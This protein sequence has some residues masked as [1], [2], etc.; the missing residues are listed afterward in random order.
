MMRTETRSA[1]QPVSR[2]L[3][4]LGLASLM[5]VPLGAQGMPDTSPLHQMDWGRQTFVYAEVLDYAPGLTARPLLLD[6]AGWMGGSSHRLWLK[7]DAQ[8]ATIGGGSSGNYQA[9]YGRLISPYWDVQ[10]GVRADLT[11]GGGATV[12]RVGGVVGLQGVAPHWF[13]LEPSLFV[14]T[15]GKVSFDLTGS[16]DLYVTQRLVLQPRL[17][18]SVSFA[19]DREFGIGS[20][21]SDGS[22]ALRARFEVRREFAPYVGVLWERRFGRTADF[23]RAG[24]GDVGETLLV[25]GLRFWR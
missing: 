2:W 11:S 15:D 18:T 13:E 23:A 22:L 16:Y 25:V 4:A 17:E 1:L 19:D 24:G 10:V 20:G 7:A 5:A 21:L 9:L 8:V 3:A 12:S 14:T 6:V